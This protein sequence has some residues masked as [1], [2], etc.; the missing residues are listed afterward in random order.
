MAA[1]IVLVLVSL[2]LDGEAVIRSGDVAVMA[3]GAGACPSAAGVAA[4]LGRLAGSAPTRDVADRAE[5]DAEATGI[6]V[7]LYRADGALVGERVIATG[8]DCSERAAAAAVVIATWEAALRSDVTL[9]LHA[10]GADRAPPPAPE[11]S[12]WSLSVA[13]QG[14]GVASAAGS[15]TAG[16]AVDFQ[17]AHARGFG[18][19]GAVWATGFRSQD[20]GG[21]S[22]RARWARWAVGVGPSY[23]HAAGHLMLSAFGQLAVG[24]IFVTGEG[25][26]RTYSDWSA[27]LGARAGLEVGLVRRGLSPVLGVGAVVWPGSQRARADGVQ[28]TAELPAIDMF[29]SL[30]LRWNPGGPR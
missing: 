10:M 14:L 12:P 5:V 19:R 29:V 3:R 4:E 7:H 11:P 6:R 8:A 15:W 24:Q 25:F 18:L 2:A 27:N 26:D 20:L 9:E 17:L 22:G 16:G 21:E 30:G 1:G 23:Q 28:E 13:A